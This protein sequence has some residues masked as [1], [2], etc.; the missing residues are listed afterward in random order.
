MV[1]FSEVTGGLRV[2]KPPARRE[3]CFLFATY[4][5]G[6]PRAPIY[7][8]NTEGAKLP[9]RYIAEKTNPGSLEPK[10]CRPSLGKYEFCKALNA[11]CIYEDR[12]VCP[13]NLSREI[14]R[15]IISFIF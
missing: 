6:K 14:W 3:G 13:M 12:H 11:M 2:G 8:G 4:Q 9:H 1:D 15:G 7:R 10:K 5:W